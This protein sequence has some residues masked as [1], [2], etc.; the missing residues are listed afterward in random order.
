M[1][2]TGYCSDSGL[3]HT[4]ERTDTVRVARWLSGRASD[5]RSSSRGFEARP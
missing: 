3:G 4:R 1:I 2:G 5:L